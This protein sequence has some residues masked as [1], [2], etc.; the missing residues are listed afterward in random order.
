M[1]KPTVT[2]N[3]PFNEAVINRAYEIN[4]K[5]NDSLYTMTQDLRSTKPNSMGGNV[6]RLGTAILHADNALDASKNL[7]TAT[8][9]PTAA[10][11]SY[12]E[13]AN[14]LTGEVGQFVTGG[15][16][17]VDEGKKIQDD[18]QSHFQGTRDAALNKIVELSGGKLKA[19]M[20]QYKN[21]TQNEFPT[22]RVF[23]DPDIKASLVKHGILNASASGKVVVTAPDG[24]QHPFEN[25]AQAD[26]FKAL[27][28]DQVNVHV[29]D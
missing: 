28:G 18:L 12:N 13:A 19:Q 1:K 6:T 24:S 3:N 26:K 8:G 25:Q 29:N 27:A 4:P 17:T 22:D 15:K 11:A 2:R 16:L 9:L 23:N 20:E 14:F 7:G 10:R 5:L 21:A